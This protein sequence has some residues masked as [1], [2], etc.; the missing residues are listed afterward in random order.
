MFSL[1]LITPGAWSVYV[2][3][4]APQGVEQVTD[5]TD[6]PGIMLYNII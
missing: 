3:V 1:S 5:G 2:W 4:Y 6:L